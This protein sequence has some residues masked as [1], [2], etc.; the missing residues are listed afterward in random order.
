VSDDTTANVI[1]IETAVAQGDGN[2]IEISIASDVAVVD[3]TAAHDGTIVCVDVLAVGSDLRSSVV[4]DS[5]AVVVADDDSR[6][7]VVR[8]DGT[9]DRM[10]MLL[11]GIDVAVV[12]AERGVGR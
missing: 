4:E 7:D 1:V 3:D 6:V 10:M 2:V 5:D 11:V 9:V 8:S 12:S